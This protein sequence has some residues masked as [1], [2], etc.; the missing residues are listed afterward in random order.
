MG[1]VILTSPVIR[2]IHSQLNSEIHF[3]IKD[4][5]KDLVSHSPF[6]RS[7]HTLSEN[8]K[9]T[10]SELEKENFDLI[11]DLQKNRKSK[12]IAKE[13][14]KETISFDKLNVKKWFLVQSGINLLPEVHL[15]DRY[16]N[17]LKKLGITND[18]LGN[19]LFIPDLISAS[20]A[21]LNLPKKYIALGIGAQHTGK[22]LSEEQL[23]HIIKNTNI[24]I[25]LLGGKREL[26][27][28]KRLFEYSNDNVW[29]LTAN[30]SLLETAE[31]IKHSVI[32]ISGDTGV[33]HMAS[34]FKVPQISIWGCTSPALG[35]FPYKGHNHS[36]MI[37][38]L[39]H[40]KRPCTKLGNRC[41][42][43]PNWCIQSINPKRI[44]DGIKL[45]LKK[46]S[47]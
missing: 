35:M 11:L 40:L 23:S 24:P 21:K 36:I 32:T 26:E 13:L 19:E 3:L 14:N 46:E 39:M 30:S 44:T 1:D 17:S 10:I 15:I 38:P 33:M 7:V 41:K 2:S 8:L 22:C 45:I 27:I 20:I 47:F 29:N 18:G 5:F 28:S 16:F 37:E 42:Y 9:S 4:S 31:I 6:V 34:A 25:V 12:K 43:A